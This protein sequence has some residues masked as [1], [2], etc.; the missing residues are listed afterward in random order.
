MTIARLWGLAC[1]WLLFAGGAPVLA[2]QIHLECKMSN[3]TNAYFQP[4]A[5]T[6]HLDTDTGIARVSD[7]LVAKAGKTSAKGKIE[8]Y[9]EIRLSVTWSLRDLPRDPKLS[10]DATAANI[11]RQRLTVRVGGAGTL[12]SVT[13]G[14]NY[15]SSREFRADATCQVKG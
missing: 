11:L 2:T 8:T 6:L 15:T 3:R 5:I 10:Y 13:A 14:Q 12:V 9:N 7:E 4:D 1:L